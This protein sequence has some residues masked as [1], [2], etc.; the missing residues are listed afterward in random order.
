MMRIEEATSELPFDKRN[1]NH[2]KP[3]VN[4]APVRKVAIGLQ[5]RQQAAANPYLFA[6]TRPIA[7]ACKGVLICY[8][9]SSTTYA[10]RS[11]VN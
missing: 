6:G 10:L 4:P 8:Y 3:R 5:Y 7:V 1:G 9:H 11:K 2:G